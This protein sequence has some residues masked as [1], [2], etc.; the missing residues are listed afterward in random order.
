MSL[1]YT[2]LRPSFRE[3]PGFLCRFS[4]SIP[5]PVGA[6]GPAFSVLKEV[7]Q[8]GLLLLKVSPGILRPSDLCFPLHLWFYINK[9]R[10]F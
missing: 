5:L 7:P 3:D 4:P 2:R 6:S 8:E 1:L 10:N 9:L